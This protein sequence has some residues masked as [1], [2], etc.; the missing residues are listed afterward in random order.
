V[1]ESANRKPPS[2]L[3]R[4]TELLRPGARPAGGPQHAEEEPADW[5]LVPGLRE[6]WN[7]LVTG[8]AKLAPRQWLAES[9]LGD[10]IRLVALS[11][12]CGT[13]ERE[14]AWAR[15]GQFQRLDAI[16]LR[17]ALV[18][19]AKGRASLEGLDAVLHSHAVDL[20]SFGEPRSYDV[21][22]A[23]N[24]ISHYAPMGRTLGR[25]FKLLKPGG[26]FFLDAYVGPSRYRWTEEQAAATAELLAQLPERYRER[27][28]NGEVKTGV[29]K[30]TLLTEKLRDP[31]MARESARIMPI[32]EKGFEVLVIRGY[33]GAVLHPL[34]DDI[35]HHFVP[36][37]RKAK[38][39]I[40]GCVAFEDERLASGSLPHD[41]VVVA[42]RKRP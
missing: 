34:F 26:L 13:G 9:F 5:T 37:D 18:R 29:H 2:R 25:V 33:G 31:Y 15:T 1:F 19:R 20:L 32:L 16:D 7:K 30:P 42:A 6:R 36:E 41:F 11:V 40:D 14:R 22:I 39:L 10:R 4:L 17:E 28:S 38:L 27:R 3:T 8:D 24:T 21:V 23:E 12:G 35:A